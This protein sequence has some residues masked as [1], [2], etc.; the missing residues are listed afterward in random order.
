VTRYTPGPG[1]ESPPEPSVSCTA[2]MGGVEPACDA[3]TPE[4]GGCWHCTECGTYGD[5]TDGCGCEGCEYVRG[6]LRAAADQA[7]LE[8]LEVVAGGGLPAKASV[9]RAMELLRRAS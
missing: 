9:E 6:E 4:D 8:C 3:D 2:C 7:A 1:D 5:P